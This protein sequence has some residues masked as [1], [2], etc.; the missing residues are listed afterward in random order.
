MS[1]PIDP[2]KPME[3]DRQL[4][5]DDILR[6]WEEKGAK[7]E[8]ELCGHP[9]WKAHNEKG[10]Y[11][12]YIATD[13]VVH[14]LRIQSGVTDGIICSPVIYLSCDNCGN[15][16]LINRSLILSWLRNIRHDG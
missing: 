3:P 11:S 4:T 16:R 6:F 10:A 14:Q 15:V 7:A 2:T 9:G 12:A 1:T 13:P 5:P 8:C